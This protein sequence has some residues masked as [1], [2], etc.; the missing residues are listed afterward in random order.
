MGRAS[1]MPGC[2]ARGDGGTSRY[3]PNAQQE[4]ITRYTLAAARSRSRSPP[5]PN[6][7]TPHPAGARKPYHILPHL[8][9]VTVTEKEGAEEKEKEER[10]TSNSN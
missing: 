4:K 3:T 8:T 6:R 1:R 5:Y 9:T 10:R 7:C 2:A